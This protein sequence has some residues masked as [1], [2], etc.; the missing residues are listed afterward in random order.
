MLRVEITLYLTEFFTQEK[1]S[2]PLLRTQ[3]P[4][5][6][7]TVDDTLYPPTQGP[8]ANLALSHKIERSGQ[9]RTLATQVWASDISN[10]LSH[11]ID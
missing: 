6:S 10:H 3:E 7:F 8:Y 5:K 2:N 4:E 1:Q 9:E 11:P